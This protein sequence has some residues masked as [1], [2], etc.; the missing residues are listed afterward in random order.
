M[1]SQLQSG[2][3]CAPQKPRSCK[4]QAGPSLRLIKKIRQLVVL[5]IGSNDAFQAYIVGDFDER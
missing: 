1:I 2:S 5:G 4:Q 3:R